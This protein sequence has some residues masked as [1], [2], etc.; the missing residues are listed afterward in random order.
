MD[1]DTKSPTYNF[2]HSNKN[3]YTYIFSG[4][5]GQINLIIIK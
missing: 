4:F 1:A 2:G 3:S 5:C